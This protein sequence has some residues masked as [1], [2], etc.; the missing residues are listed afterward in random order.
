MWGVVWL[1]EV[2]KVVCGCVCTVFWCRC[3]RAC[4][5]VHTR[6]CVCALQGTWRAHS[7]FLFHP[8]THTRRK[9]LW[10][11]NAKH[12]EK[13]RE[14]VSEKGEGL[15]AASLWLRERW[16]NGGGTEGR[17]EIKERLVHQGAPNL[18]LAMSNMEHSAG[19]SNRKASDRC[20]LFGVNSSCSPVLHH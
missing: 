17:R 9:R 1:L 13:I 14:R 4:V 12:S 20:R 16:K 3:V 2:A 10:E 18:L 15:S 8:T 11:R 19:K 6:V 5:C 7:N